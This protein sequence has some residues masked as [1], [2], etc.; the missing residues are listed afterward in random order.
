MIFLIYFSFSVKIFFS[1]VEFLLIH[2]YMVGVLVVN[3]DFSLLGFFKS[4]KKV[5]NKSFAANFYAKR[6]H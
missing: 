2:C 1:Y 6:V 5:L 3:F 4:L